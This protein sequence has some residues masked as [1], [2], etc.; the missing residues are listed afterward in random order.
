MP[1][2]GMPVQPSRS[3]WLSALSLP[4][5]LVLRLLVIIG[6]AANEQSVL[7]SA[8]TAVT[9][10]SWQLHVLYLAFGTWPFDW[11]MKRNRMYTTMYTPTRAGQCKEGWPSSPMFPFAL[12]YIM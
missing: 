11:N 10:H 4:K 9:Q 1:F 12:Q 6:C 7:R 2:T 8:A 3:V 5:L